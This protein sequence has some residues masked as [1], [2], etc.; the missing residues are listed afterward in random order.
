MTSISVKT[1][2]LIE[3]SIGGQSAGLLPVF[4][5][6]R[7]WKGLNDCEDVGR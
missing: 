3:I 7:K 4:R 5:Y 2:R 6:A 1:L